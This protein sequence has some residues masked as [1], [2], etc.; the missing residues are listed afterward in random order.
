MKK[1]YNIT[2]T[3][4]REEAFLIRNNTNFHL[5]NHLFLV[6]L[7]DEHAVDNEGAIFQM[8]DQDS[9]KE[10]EENANVL[11]YKGNSGIVYN[12]AEDTVD[13]AAGS[14]DLEI[15]ANCKEQAELLYDEIY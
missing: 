9:A 11:Q 10:I 4:L 2:G 8:V 14:E 7:D 3:Q 1:I 13:F 15:Y 5:T 6:Q 12:Y